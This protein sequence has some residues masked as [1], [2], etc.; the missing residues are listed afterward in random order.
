MQLNPAVNTYL[1]LKDLSKPI[2]EVFLLL[3]QICRLCVDASS[4]H[5]WWGPANVRAVWDGLFFATWY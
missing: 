1:L 4:D 5:R 3:G 2:T